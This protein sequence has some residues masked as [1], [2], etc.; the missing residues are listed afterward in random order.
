MNI[1]KL[2][3]EGQKARINAEMAQAISGVP[4][5]FTCVYKRPDKRQYYLH[6]WNSVKPIDIEVAVNK[7]TGKLLNSQQQIAQ[8]K[9]QLK[10]KKEY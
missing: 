7:A 9:N 8:I 2:I 3:A 5:T 4:V 1:A 6:G 10:N